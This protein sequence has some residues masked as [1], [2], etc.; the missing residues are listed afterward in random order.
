M[1][2]VYII[3]YYLWSR[4]KNINVWV[5]GCVLV[6]VCARARMCVCVCVAC[7]LLCVYVFATVKEEI[8]C[9]DEQSKERGL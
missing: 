4:T 6:C 2:M 7:V 1:S 9:H 8:R 5:V 3:L